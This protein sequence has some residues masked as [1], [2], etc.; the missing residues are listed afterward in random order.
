MTYPFLSL[1]L[2]LT[3]VRA[4]LWAAIFVVGNLALPFACHH[5]P[6]GNLGIMLLPIYFFT[7][8]AAYKFGWQVGLLTALLSPLLNSLLLGMPVVAALPIIMTKSALLSGFAWLVAWRS[9]KL[10]LLHLLAVVLAYQ[11]VGSAIEML[12]YGMAAGMAEFQNAWAGMLLQVVGGYFI[13]KILAK[14]D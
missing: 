4:L 8:I 3:H 2:R 13:L 7:L 14:Y 11:F 12:L 10:S 6:V 1:N 5:A 9:G